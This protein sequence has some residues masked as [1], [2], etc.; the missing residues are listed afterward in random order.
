MTQSAAEV[1]WTF[2]DHL[3]Y[4]RILWADALEVYS[5]DVFVRHFNTWQLG[6]GGVVISKQPLE[7]NFARDAAESDCPV[8][9]GIR[10][11][12]EALVIRELA[13]AGRLTDS[14][15]KFLGI[16]LRN[17]AACVPDP[18]VWKEVKLLTDPLGSH[19]PL[20][21]LAPYERFVHIP[22]PGAAARA[23][24]GRHGTFV[25][26]DALLDRFG[27]DSL[28]DWLALL[29]DTGLLSKGYSVGSTHAATPAAHAETSVVENRPE[30]SLS[31]TLGDGIPP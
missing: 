26:T 28:G 6:V 14:Q 29:S 8:W 16:R 24:H 13:T 5:G 12:I 21:A 9:S 7:L 22:E 11:V 20:S 25:V 15:R 31:F 23:A 17:L 18:S 10:K 4:Y 30:N 19:L 1:F 27:T 3:A 2:E